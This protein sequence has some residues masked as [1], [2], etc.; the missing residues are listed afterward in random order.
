M[1]LLDSIGTD[2]LISPTK[3]TIAINNATETMKLHYYLVG[4]LPNPHWTPTRSRWPAG[5]T[6]T[7][8][9]L[10]E[11]T[12]KQ[13]MLVG[14]TKLSSWQLAQG[15]TYYPILVSSLSVGQRL[16]SVLEGKLY[17]QQQLQTKRLALMPSPHDSHGSGWHN[18][19]NELIWRAFISLSSRW[20]Q[21]NHKI[22]VCVT[23]ID[24]ASGVLP[25]M[26]LA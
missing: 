22:C 24:T 5:A 11:L 8:D 10:D 6:F 16:D 20:L 18:L 7:F 23:A 21:A 25:G 9:Y 26:P 1:T 3:V 12:A 4:T 13:K 17:E 14:H 15:I 2:L 19:V